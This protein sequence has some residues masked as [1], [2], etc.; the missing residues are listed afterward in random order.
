MAAVPSRCGA[1]GHAPSLGLRRWKWRKNKLYH[2]LVFSLI[3]FFPLS[4]RVDFDTP[5]E[6]KQ[7][8]F[9]RMFIKIHLFPTMCIFLHYFH[10]SHVHFFQSP[11]FHRDSSAAEFHYFFTFQF[12]PVF[13]HRGQDGRIPAISSSRLRASFTHFGSR[14]VSIRG[15][16]ILPRQILCRMDGM[17]IGFILVTAQYWRPRSFSDAPKW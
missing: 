11:A 16:G 6:R 14:L 15:C 3:S 8:H 12:P 7:E 9:E 10:S 5:K 17:N 13:L 1:W 4:V 2:V